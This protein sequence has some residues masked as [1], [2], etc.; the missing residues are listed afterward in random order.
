MA[1]S[2]IPASAISGTNYCKMVDGTL[3]CWGSFLESQVAANTT[4]TVDV[5]FPVPFI[6]SPRIIVTPRTVSPQYF[7]VGYTNQ[8]VSGFQIKYRNGYSDKVD[9]VGSWLAIGR[10]K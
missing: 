1:T 4:L 2:I 5:T 8:S 7:S 9:A 3:I 6:S 10:W